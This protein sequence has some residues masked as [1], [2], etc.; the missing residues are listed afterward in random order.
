MHPGGKSPGLREQ[1][2]QALAEMVSCPVGA[3]PRLAPQSNGQRRPEAL[4]CV[5]GGAEPMRLR[6]GCGSIWPPTPAQAA[7]APEICAAPPVEV[8]K[9]HKEYSQKPFVKYNP[10][11][12]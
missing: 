11:D 1:A 6:S 12:Y 8:N 2:M 4:R 10:Y 7:C 3:D 5:G 9:R